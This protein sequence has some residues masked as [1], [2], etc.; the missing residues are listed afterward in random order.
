MATES[1]GKF[2]SPSEDFPKTDLADLDGL[3]VNSENFN[4]VFVQ[5]TNKKWLRR[6]LDRVASSP[7]H[8]N[9]LIDIL[10]QIVTSD[11][12]PEW[13]RRALYWLTEI[14]QHSQLS[15]HLEA[16]RPSF[17]R[18][19][20]HSSTLAGTYDLV[21]SAAEISKK[22]EHSKPTRNSTR[23]E[24]FIRTGYVFVDDSD[25]DF[26]LSTKRRRLTKG[27]SETY[28]V[29]NAEDEEEKANETDASS[30]SLLNDSENGEET[31]DETADLPSSDDG[32]FD[33]E[34]E[35]SVSDGQVVV[36]NDSSVQTRTSRRPI[37]VSDSEDDEG[38]DGSS[39]QQEEDDE[40]EDAGHVPDELTDYS[41]EEGPDSDEARQNRLQSLRSPPF[42]P[43][44][45]PTRPK[46]PRTR[47]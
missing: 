18:L 41:E 32:V 25:D 33:V 2:S 20:S 22:A 24:H 7:R 36:R 47:R 26:G 16:C 23:P 29:E 30:L 4:Q 43:S 34:D 19:L 15:S 35:T 46:R 17:T 31:Q 6:T 39:S 13:V 21:N 12:H 38:S 9:K 14:C 37:R 10:V 45:P 42:S 27:L 8:L 3:L 11:R 5:R 44:T 1:L 40:E 28:S